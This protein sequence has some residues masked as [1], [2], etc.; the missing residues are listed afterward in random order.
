[1]PKKGGFCSRARF[2]A[3]IMLSVSHWADLP[4]TSIPTICGA[5]FVPNF[6][7]CGCVFEAG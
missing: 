1:M 3:V 2:A 6:V 7:E 4:E 5:D